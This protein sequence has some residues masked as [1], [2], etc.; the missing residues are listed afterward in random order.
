MGG[1]V[2]GGA[3]VGGVVEA[4]ALDDERE[5]EGIPEEALQAAVTVTN[6]V[7]TSR[8]RA[9]TVGRSCFI[10]VGAVERRVAGA[11]SSADR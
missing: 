3:V 4:E 10:G 5:V 2:V 11:G 7:A 8:P 1:G 9:R 6:A